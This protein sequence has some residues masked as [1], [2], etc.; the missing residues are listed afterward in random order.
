ML[1]VDTVRRG[2]YVTLFSASLWAALAVGACGGDDSEDDDKSTPANDAGSDTGSPPVDA[3]SDTGS[4]PT[5]ASTS[6]SDASAEELATALGQEGVTASARRADLVFPPACKQGVACKRASSVDACVT[7]NRAMYDQAA[8][9]GAA[10]GFTEACLDA[11]LD[12]WGCFARTPVCDDFDEKCGPLFDTQVS[13]CPIAPDA[14][15]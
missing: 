2:R 11:T 3:G 7:S 5:D 14:G 8:S 9:R 4:P 6:T 13:L 15:T 10:S 1:S 12:F